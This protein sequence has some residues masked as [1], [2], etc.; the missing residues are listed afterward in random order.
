[1]RILLTLFFISILGNAQ[2]KKLTIS[3]RS[4]IPISDAILLINQTPKYITDSLGNVQIHTS[5]YNK[6]ITIRHLN[7]KTERFENWIS[8]DTLFLEEAIKE[9]QEILIKNSSKKEE[10]ILYYPKASTS[11]LLPKNFGNSSSINSNTELSIFFPIENYKGKIIQK[12]YIHTCDYK[13]I[14][15]IQNKKSSKLRGAKYSPI[16]VN[17]YTVDSI[18]NVPLNKIFQEDFIIACQVKN[19]YALLELSVDEEFEF[20][21]NG[22]FVSIKNL[23]NTDYENLGFISPPGIELIGISKNNKI[24]PYFRYLHQGDEALWQKYNYLINRSNTYKVGIEL[25]N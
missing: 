21:S 11:N 24:I 12:L 3:S 6:T 23:S 22:I 25:K 4:K 14:D 18:Y 20:P 19:D 7:F 2:T 13:V 16:K 5:D 15:N 1:M 9:I 17:F 8:K 10:N